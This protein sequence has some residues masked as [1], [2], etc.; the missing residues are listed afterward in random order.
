MVDRKGEGRMRVFSHEMWL[1]WLGM[2]SATKEGH[3]VSYQLVQ[4]QIR[5]KKGSDGA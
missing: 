5:K 2:L 4:I 3:Q 1:V